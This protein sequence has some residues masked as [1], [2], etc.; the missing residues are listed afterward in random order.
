[1]NNKATYRAS[2]F[3]QAAEITREVSFCQSQYL[4]KKQLTKD[5]VT[6]ANSTLSNA[7]RGF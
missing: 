5:F 6:S 7:K 2:R 3:L 4:Q 1:M